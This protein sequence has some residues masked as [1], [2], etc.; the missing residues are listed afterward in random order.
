MEFLLICQFEIIIIKLSTID[1]IEMASNIKFGIKKNLIQ[2][3]SN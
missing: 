1:K 2:K 3:Y